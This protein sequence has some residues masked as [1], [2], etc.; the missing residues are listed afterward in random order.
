M[1]CIGLSSKDELVVRVLR[2]LSE[3]LLQ[4]SKVVVHRHRIIVARS[5]RG[6]RETDLRRALNVQDIR[7]SVPTVGVLNQVALGIGIEGAILGQQTSER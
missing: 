7:D 4:A 3:E 1:A 6:D 2:E 5:A